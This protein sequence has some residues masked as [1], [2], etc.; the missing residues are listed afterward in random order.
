M[1]G[2]LI[3]F[4][5]DMRS[6]SNPT[7]IRSGTIIADFKH[8]RIL[9]SKEPLLGTPNPA[10]LRRVNLCSNPEL[11]RQILRVLAAWWKKGISANVIENFSSY[12][13]YDAWRKEVYFEDHQITWQLFLVKNGGDF[14]AY[15]AL[16]SSLTPELEELYTLAK[17]VRR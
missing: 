9:F 10:R 16:N 17:G 8:K 12:D 7:N 1:R 5:E 6:E 13:A 4:C 11:P 15:I 2:A 14:A 3:T